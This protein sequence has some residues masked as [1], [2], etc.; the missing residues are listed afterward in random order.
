MVLFAHSEQQ[1]S[2]ILLGLASLID[3]PEPTNALRPDVAEMFVNNRAGY[4]AQVAA[5]NSRNAAM[6]A[7]LHADLGM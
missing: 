2:Q 5:T 4:N 7:A 1:S 6:L 3:N